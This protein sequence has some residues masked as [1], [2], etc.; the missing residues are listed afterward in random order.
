MSHSSPELQVCLLPTNGA[1]VVSEQDRGMQPKLPVFTGTI[2]L[3][4]RFRRSRLPL[5]I[6]PNHWHHRSNRS[7]PRVSGHNSSSRAAETPVW[8][9]VDL[10]VRDRTTGVAEDQ[11]SY[12]GIIELDGNSRNRAGAA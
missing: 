3:E 4:E 11:F 6:H 8:N 7:E 9:A 5:F 1:A 2:N 10:W 12:E